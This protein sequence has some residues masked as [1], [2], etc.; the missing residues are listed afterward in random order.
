MDITE[1][2][3]AT[4]PSAFACVILAAGEAVRMGRPKPALAF[5]SSTMVGAV[6]DAAETAELAPV[7]VV[8]GFHELEVSGAVGSVARVVHNP[9]PGAGNVSSLLVGMDACG[10]VDG[11]V[12][13]L[14]DMPG[15]N[16]E[17]IRQL[18]EGMTESGSRAGWV[19]YRNGRGHPLALARS[20][21]GDVQ[22]LRGPKALWPFLSSMEPADACVVRSDEPRPLDVNTPDDYRR[23][24]GQPEAR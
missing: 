9:D 16:W 22:S 4:R 20:V 24:T 8:T 2:F 1:Q 23:L 7:V 12:L 13:L 18:A 14:G 6:V 5:G 10:D 17:L 21:F 15:V 11:I 3:T 19:E